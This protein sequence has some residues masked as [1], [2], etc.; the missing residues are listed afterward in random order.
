MMKKEGLNLLPNKDIDEI[1]KKI[2][3]EKEEEEKSKKG[4]R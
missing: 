1:V 2:T 4:S 3:A